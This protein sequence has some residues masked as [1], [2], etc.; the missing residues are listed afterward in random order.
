MP[1]KSLWK[2]FSYWKYVLFLIPSLG[3]WFTLTVYP[4]LQTIPL[5]LFR[6]KTT[7]SE[8]SF[9]GLSNFKRVLSQPIL[10]T[11]LRNTLFYILFLLV[12]QSFFAIVLALTLQKN[13]RHNR[14]FRT[15]FFIPITFS[16]VLVGLTWGYMY[17]PNVGIINNILTSIGLHGFENFSWLGSATGGILAI[18]IVHAWAGVGIPMTFFIAGLQ[19]IPKDLYEAA[20]IDGSTSIQSFIHITFPM[21]LPIFLR[22]SL[23]TFVAGAMTFDYVYLL[24]SSVAS[25]FDTWMVAIYRSIGQINAN[26]GVPC[27]MGVLLM[28]PLIIFY[29][30][31]YF[32]NKKSEEYIGVR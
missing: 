24:G 32:A 14:I 5:S 12:I 22:I 31:Q 21:M 13:T 30:L 6:W 17:D 19:T 23:L 3:V 11:Q 15:F 8:M 1:H 18:V 26:M 28:I 20:T 10:L 27:A 16:S 4:N 25:P 7:S 9:V 29:V 2:R